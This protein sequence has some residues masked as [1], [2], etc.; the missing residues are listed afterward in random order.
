MAVSPPAAV[1]G[2]ATPD[3]IRMQPCGVLAVLDA[4]PMQPC[5]GLAPLDASPMQPCEGLAPLDAS[6]LQ[7]AWDLHHSTQVSCNLQETC[8]TRRKSPAACVGLA[9]LAASPMQPCD[10]LAVLDASPMQPC[11]GLAILDANIKSMNF[12]NIK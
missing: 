2:L 3:A 11:E 10:G 4:S 8:T 9:T 1:R 12:I 6:L 5:E 7:L